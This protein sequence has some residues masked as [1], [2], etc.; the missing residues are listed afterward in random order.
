LREAGQDK[1]VEQRAALSLD[2]DELIAAGKALSQEDRDK[3]QR[4]LEAF[5]SKPD[6]VA[7]EDAAS[8]S[9]SSAAAAAAGGTRDADHEA[10]KKAAFRWQ[11]HLLT[12]ILNGN[13]IPVVRSEVLCGLKLGKNFRLDEQKR[14]YV[15]DVRARAA[16]ACFE[17]NT[18]HV[19]A[20]G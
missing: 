20:D 16:H 2:E 7:A 17:T 18:T 8:S 10:K 9:S 13:L 3:L 5:L 12:Y 4:K 11:A 19:F 15:I 1:K 6:A 14:V